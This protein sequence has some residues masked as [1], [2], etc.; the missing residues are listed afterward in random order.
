MKALLWTA[1]ERIEWTDVPMPAP[2]DGELLIKVHTVG[3]CGSDLEGYLGHNSLRKPPLLMGHEFSGTVEQVGS[4]GGFAPGQ[5]V[6]VNPLSSCGRCRLCAQGLR[7]LCDRR[8]LIG[9]HRAGAYAEYVVV[10]SDNAVALPDGLPFET[11]A[12]TEPLACSFRAARR[13]M[14]GHALADVAVVGAGAIGLLAAYSARIMG[15]SAI[16]VIDVNEA[17]LRTAERLGIGVPIDARGDVEREVKRLRG[18]SGVDV[19]I[20]AAGFQPTRT[21]AASLVRTGGVIMNVGLGIDDTSVPINRFIRSEV[22]VKGSFCYADSDF[23]DALRLL[24]DSKV[25]ERGWTELRPL[26]AG[27]DAFRELVSGR[28][29]SGKILLQS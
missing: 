20:D 27:A 21:L 1:P 25:S 2:A 29:P 9:I 11:A 3:V 5:R 23:Q 12:L 17:R 10:P 14:A 6:V 8:C 18:E 22:D 26:S 24:A 7:Q 28:C 13:A 16:Y 4:G 15:A 19:V